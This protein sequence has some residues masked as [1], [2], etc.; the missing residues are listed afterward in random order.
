MQRFCVSCLLC[1]PLASRLN[2]DLCFGDCS[3]V[4]HTSLNV[5]H[6]CVLRCGQHILERY[7]LGWP[8]AVCSYKRCVTIYIYIYILYNTYKRASRYQTASASGRLV[9]HMFKSN[10]GCIDYERQAGRDSC[11][12]NRRATLDAETSPRSSTCCC[13]C[14][15]GSAQRGSSTNHRPLGRCSSGLEWYSFKTHNFF[16]FPK[17]PGGPNN[18][19]ERVTKTTLEGHQND[20]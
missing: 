6:G 14:G 7:N 9:F 20:P 17:F 2:F 19:P 12:H 10:V 18:T 15:V 4:S 13:T 3:A 1:L 8:K 16:N 11:L 5:W